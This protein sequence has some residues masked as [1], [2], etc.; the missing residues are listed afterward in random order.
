MQPCVARSRSCRG[1]CAI[2]EAFK[3]IGVGDRAG[4][5]ATRAARMEA[6]RGAC[7]A[8]SSVDDLRR[9]DLHS[10]QVLSVLV[11]LR[12][13]P[14]VAQRLLATAAPISAS[15]SPSAW[16]A[17]TSRRARGLRAGRMKCLVRRAHRH[18]LPR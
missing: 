12:V 1:C 16:L 13:W 9:R 4:S 2:A 3:A 11:V 5:G 7:G 6:V 8:P 10:P 15:S 17:R 14:V 18:E